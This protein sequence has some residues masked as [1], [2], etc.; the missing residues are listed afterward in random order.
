MAAMTPTQRAKIEAIIEAYKDHIEVRINHG[1]MLTSRN[2]PITVK[3]IVGEIEEV[4]EGE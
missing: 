1:S 2:K 4:L 3:Q